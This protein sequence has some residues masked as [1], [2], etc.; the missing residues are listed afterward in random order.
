MPR[1]HVVRDL[2]AEEF[3]FV[4]DHLI[5]GSTDR[6]VELAFLKQFD[7]KLAKSSFGRWRKAVGEELAD[8]YR[9]ARY[10]AKQLQIDLNE[11]GKD[12]YQTVIGNIEDRLLTSMREVIAQDPIKLL[13]IRQEEEKR[14]LKERE[15]GIKERALALEEEKARGL[16]LDVEA[17]PG[18]VV[19]HLL[20]FIGEDPAG[21]G[22][23]QKNAKKFE[24]FLVE[25]LNAG[26]A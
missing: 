4:I 25:R 15:L 11:E 26:Q 7:K 23:F 5:A 17:L 14:R 9:L 13:G 20:E 22:W 3:Q 10:T 19:E 16:K 8:R 2:S 12:K 24:S 21:L 1:R 6:E 18:L